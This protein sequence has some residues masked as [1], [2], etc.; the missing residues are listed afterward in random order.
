MSTKER[1]DADAVEV[2]TTAEI[3]TLR[4]QVAALTARVEAAEREREPM[5]KIREAVGDFGSG[6]T[7]VVEKLIAAKDAAVARVAS[8]EVALNEAEDGL[9]E[10]FDAVQDFSFPECEV[11]CNGHHESIVTEAICKEIE[12]DVDAKLALIADALSGGTSALDVHDAALREEI[13]RE[14]ESHAED[15][16]SMH[17]RQAHRII[18]QR[19]VAG[20]DVLA[21]IRAKGGK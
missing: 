21:T 4:E 12:P 16:D 14:V 10:A 9:A 6:E 17:W 7:V 3:E 2:R 1:G 19:I 13:A 8:L 5:R 20:A 15:V 18:A 11:R